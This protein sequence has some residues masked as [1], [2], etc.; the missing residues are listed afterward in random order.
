MSFSGKKCFPTSS[1]GTTKRRGPERTPD[2]SYQDSNA[3][4]PEIFDV[5]IFLTL[6]I[7]VAYGQRRPMQVIIGGP[8]GLWT[9]SAIRPRPAYRTGSRAREAG[10]RSGLPFCRLSLLAPS[11]AERGQLKLLRLQSYLVDAEL[12]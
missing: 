11:S 2:F 10:F 1:P 6:F 8:R 5:A 12:R 9:R 3:L 4:I 7:P